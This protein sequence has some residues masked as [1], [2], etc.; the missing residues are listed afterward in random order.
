M[1]RAIGVALAVCVVAF[2]IA[3]TVAYVRDI[4]AQ[5]ERQL[6]AETD[7]MTAMRQ[8][9]A[10]LLNNSTAGMIADADRAAHRRE[11]DEQRRAQAK[12]EARERTLVTA[13]KRLITQNLHDPASAR[14][15]DD[16]YVMPYGSQE[17]VS[18]T[19]RARNAF[20]ALR[21]QSVHCVVNGD[22]IRIGDD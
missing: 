2:V 4:D 6:H 3:S 21:V 16:G 22:T 10:R 20:N 5:R 8:E 14:W 11:A 18:I 13:C 9:A 15:E 7:R 19:L 1:N 12:A 17:R